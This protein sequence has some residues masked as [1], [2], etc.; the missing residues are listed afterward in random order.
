LVKG[1]TG[2]KGGKVTRDDCYS[3]RLAAEL[4]TP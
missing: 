2:V 4:L 3:N 1:A